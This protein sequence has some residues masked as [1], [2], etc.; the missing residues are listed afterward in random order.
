[1]YLSVEEAARLGIPHPFQVRPGGDDIRPLDVPLR[2]TLAGDDDFLMRGQLEHRLGIAVP[3]VVPGR[4]LHSRV[5]A[6]AQRAE[7]LERQAAHEAE[8]AGLERDFAASDGA[9]VG[10]RQAGEPARPTAPVP[11]SRPAAFVMMLTTPP[12]A[13]LP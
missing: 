4:R 6:P 5:P 9:G 11:F 7:A 2:H 8:R 13:S 1:M 3:F 12:S 10:R